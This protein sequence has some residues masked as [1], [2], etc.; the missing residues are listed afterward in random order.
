MAQDDST[1]AAKGNITNRIM[2]EF[3]VGLQEGNGGRVN[4]RTARRL[5][6]VG[7]PSAFACAFSGS[8]SGAPPGARLAGKDQIAAPQGVEF[9]RA[10]LDAEAPGDRSPSFSLARLVGSDDLLV[11]P[12]APLADLKD[13]EDV[14]GRIDPVDD[15]YDLRLGYAELRGHPDAEAAHVG[16]RLDIDVTQKTVQVGAGASGET[17][18]R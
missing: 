18:D 13:H 15:G 12:A 5:L 17:G 11:R 2:A 16:P 14:G 8:F 6:V 1:S 9:R 3:L 10:R 7:L 4:A